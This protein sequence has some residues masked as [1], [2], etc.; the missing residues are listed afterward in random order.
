LT[1]LYML[2]RSIVAPTSPLYFQVVHISILGISFLL[3][4]FGFSF[5]VSE[6]A[7]GFASARV[8]SRNTVLALVVISGLLSLPMS[9]PQSFLVLLLIQIAGGLCLGGV[10]VLGRLMVPRVVSPEERAKSFGY[11]GLVFAFGTM[12]GS[13]LGGAVYEVVGLSWSFV[14][15]AAVSMLPLIPLGFLDFGRRAGRLGAPAEGESAGQGDGSSLLG[16]PELVLMGL[17]G[18]TTAACSIFYNLLLPNILTRDPTF[19]AGVFDVSLVIAVFSFSSGAFQPIMGMG[20]SRNPKAWI[21]AALVGTGLTFGLL[22]LSRG[23]LEVYVVAFLGGAAA[24]AITPL[25]LSVLS[26][27]VPP[28]KLGRVF[29]LYGAAEDSGIIVGS[30]A[31]GLVWA[32]MGASA[33]FL[34]MAMLFIGVGAVYGIVTASAGRRSARAKS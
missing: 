5:L 6:A 9:R 25:A 27:G 3:G 2:G 7:W 26:S 33:V 18:L 23:L 15:A 16:R 14:V 4:G 19:S 28:R 21:F 29:G 30:L 31:G 10:G 22:L 32:E 17:V 12:A 20:G 11:L 24:A 8:W 1:F 34:S 13:L